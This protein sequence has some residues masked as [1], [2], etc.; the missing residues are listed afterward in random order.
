MRGPALRQRYGAERRVGVG[1]GRLLPIAVACRLLLFGD[2]REGT[3]GPEQSAPPG[4]LV[5][6]GAREPA[7]G[8]QVDRCL[9]L[10]RAVQDGGG[11][12]RKPD[13]YL[14]ECRVALLLQLGLPGGEGAVE[15]EADA[16]GVGDV[17]GEQGVGDEQDGRGAAVRGGLEGDADL[18]PLGEVG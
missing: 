11:E 1:E 4:V 6:E 3:A 2:A 9:Q 12:P 10:D 14:G 13:R 16:V 17:V 15:A 7:R 5:A 8:L 18:L